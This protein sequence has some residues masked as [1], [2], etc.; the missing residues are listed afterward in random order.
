[1]NPGDFRH[2][3]T[4]FLPSDETDDDGFP[5]GEPTEY[6]T[7]WA[8]LKTLKGRTFYEA[9]QNNMQY[10]REFTI[11]YHKKLDDEMRPKN[12]QILWKGKVHDIVSIENDDGLNRTM[13]VIVKAV[14]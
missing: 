5:K 12:L 8:K 2:R 4:F 1:M 10:N 11:R 7:V 13:T 9:A 14:E 3:I 6:L